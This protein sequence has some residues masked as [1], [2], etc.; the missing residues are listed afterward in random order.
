MGNLESLIT[1]HSTDIIWVLDRDRNPVYVSPAVERICGFTPEEAI[2]VGLAG[3]VE[4]DS[5]V[6]ALK[7]IG[8]K[9]ETYIKNV[10]ESGL[11]QGKIE[12]TLELKLLHKNGGTV[13]AE[14]SIAI[15]LDREGNTDTVFGITRDISDRK[16]AE[17]AVFQIY[18][19]FIKITEKTPYGV[20][21]F[22]RSGEIIFYN[23]SFREM[24]F[25]SAETLYS[26]SVHELTALKERGS[27]EEYIQKAD[28]S[29]GESVSFRKRYITGNGELLWVNESYTLFDDDG[30][31]KIFLG[32]CENISDKVRL[33]F[34]T[35]Q[36][37]RANSLGQLAGSVSHE[38][39]NMLQVIMGYS[40]MLLEEVRED[41]PAGYAEKIRY[42]AERSLSLMRQ[43]LVFAK[44]GERENKYFPLCEAVGS[45]IQ[46]LRPVIGKNIKLDFIPPDDGCVILG[47]QGQIE[48]LLMNLCLN[49]RD[50]LSEKK[51]K[52][53]IEISV[54]KK[55]FGRKIKTSFGDIPAGTY[56]C[57]GV[58]DNG[59]GIPE[60]EQK[61]VFEPFYSTKKEGSGT[62]LGLATV[63]EISDRHNAY[64]D[65]SSLE[66]FGT[67]ITIYFPDAGSGSLS[68]GI[69][70]NTDAVSSPGTAGSSDEEKGLTTGSDGNGAEGLFPS[71]RHRRGTVLLADDD[72]EVLDYT[73]AILKKMGLN[74]IKARNGFEAVEL[75]IKNQK[76]VDLMVFDLVMPELNGHDAFQR[77]K[78]IDPSA[79]GK[80]IV[81]ITGKSD[82]TEGKS[83]GPD[84]QP[85]DMGGNASCFPELPVFDGTGIIAKPF[86]ENFF[87]NSVSLFFKKYGGRPVV[88][89]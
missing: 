40:D 55:V 37:D 48:Q 12:V 61:K 66:N 23:T 6:L 7:I 70:G 42:A 54:S 34:L 4:K 50:S 14:S 32:I 52:G 68:T 25:Y 73:E 49:A 17:K 74:V 51:E 77:I 46:L 87:R 72:E 65:V 19:R 28:L 76:A 89:Y 15:S 13:P 75:Y 31:R 38:L 33:E 79:S 82:A 63:R 35:G 58:K 86:S 16:R 21:L 47:D 41:I 71:D 43:L 9:K 11:E 69:A 80:G 85:S 22:S 57:L 1:E 60:K 67:R 8:E 5:L 2:G 81:F 20:F 36:A 29:D 45:F 10:T 83:S 27:V 53:Y 3:I 88:P 64:I 56:C 24:L 62:G 39:K 30:E 84:V 18:E 44:A 59:C 78:A 26:K